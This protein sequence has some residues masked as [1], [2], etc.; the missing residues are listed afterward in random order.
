MDPFAWYA[1]SLLAIIVGIAVGL[2]AYNRRVEKFLDLQRARD[3]IARDL[4]D[5]IAST[6]ASVALFAS[7]LKKHLKQQTPEANKLLE[8]ISSLSLDAVDSM[9]DIV[10]SVSPT[11]DTLNHTLVRMKDLVSGICD[12]HGIAH[13]V[14]IELVPKDIQ[15]M[16]E[17]RKNIYLIYK[18]ALTNI[19]KHSGARHIEVKAGLT[20]NR[21]EMFIRDDG[22]GFVLRRSDSGTSS[23]KL[24]RNLERGHGLRNMEKRAKEIGADFSIVSRTG[25]G[26]TIQLKKKMA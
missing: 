18:E 16:P 3:R 25:H 11:H 8:K 23:V 17:V 20:G 15:L 4:H 7:T 9:D 10:W 26:A 6:L 12:A 19:V 13:E 5:D 22:N 1:S 24:G 21:F 14:N 2:Y